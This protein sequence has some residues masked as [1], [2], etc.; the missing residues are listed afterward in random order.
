ME[1]GKKIA[2][3]VVL[4]V[5][6]VGALAWILSRSGVGGLGGPTPPAWVLDQQIEKIDK[7]SLE[8]QTLKLREWNKLGPDKD[9]LY[10]NKAGQYA[11]TTPMSCGACGVKIPAPAMPAETAEKGGPEAREKWEKEQ[12]CPKCGKTPFTMPD[13]TKMPPAPP[14]AK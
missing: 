14:A 7:A 1:G 11:M 3:A 5:V 9:G 2:F 12:K 8:T 6:I 10:K 4:I 13:P